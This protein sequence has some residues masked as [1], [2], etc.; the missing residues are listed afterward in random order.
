MSYQNYAIKYN[1]LD[2]RFW[3]CH[4]SLSLDLLFSNLMLLDASQLHAEVSVILCMLFINS[5]ELTSQSVT[6]QKAG[7]WPCI[8]HSIEPIVTTPTNHTHLHHTQYSS[9][10][11]S[12]VHSNLSA[13][14]LGAE[15]WQYRWIPQSRS[16]SLDMAEF[17][18]EV[19]VVYVYV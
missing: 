6:V 5:T 4:R 12:P 15:R 14:W 1:F 16:A 9:S 17:H 13:D 11:S 18:S 7:G 10:C 3:S 19:H 2:S 8:Y